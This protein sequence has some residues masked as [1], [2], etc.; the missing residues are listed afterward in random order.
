MF[1]GIGAPEKA[2]E[3]LGINYELVGYSEIDK[4]ASRSYSAIHGVPES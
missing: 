1:S 2:L 3:N 4:Y